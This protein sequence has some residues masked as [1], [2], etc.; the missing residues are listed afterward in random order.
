MTKDEKS[1]KELAIYVNHAVDGH[2]CADCSMFDPPA[3]CN[4]VAGP[5]SPAGHCSFWTAK[6]NNLRIS[7]FQ[8]LPV[9]IETSKGERR[10]QDWPIMPAHYGFITMTNSPEKND[11][12]DVFIGDNKACRHCWIIDQIHPDTEEFV[13]DFRDSW[14]CN[15]RNSRDAP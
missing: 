9:F 2:V 11:G 8:G 4:A 1:S 15:L 12:L 7:S 13:N 3:S 5:I 6:E 10:R 14:S